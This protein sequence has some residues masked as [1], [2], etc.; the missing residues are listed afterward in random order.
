MSRRGMT[1]IEVLLAMGI[2]L[3]GISALMGLFHFGG[4]LEQKARSH[5]IIAP[6][7]P[8]L[9]ADIKAQAFTLNADGSIGEMREFVHQPVTGAP[10]Y[11]YQ[12][13][14][15]PLNDPLVYHATLVVYRERIER[16]ATSVQFLLPRHVPVLRRLEF[17]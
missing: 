1:L 9:V 3:V 11:H 16:P 10:G 5:A 4:G 17:E 8:G 12:V 14:A 13:D 7:L 15:E 6:L 2:F